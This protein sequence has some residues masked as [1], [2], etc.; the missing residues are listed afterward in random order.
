MRNIQVHLSS[1]DKT[2]LKRYITKGNHYSWLVLCASK[3]SWK[4]CKLLLLF[5]FSLFGYSQ[6]TAQS[7][8][9]IC[10]ERK[11]MNE[12]GTD[13][14]LIKTCF[15]NGFK[16]ISTSYPDYAGRYFLTDSEVFVKI[17]NKYV[18]T[19]NSN[20]FNH[21]QVTLLVLINKQ[22]QK[23][24]AAF[25]ADKNVNECLSGIDCIPEY[26][27]DDLKIS[28]YQNE[29]WFEAHW[30][31]GGVCRSVDGTIVSLQVN[32]ISRYLN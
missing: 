25:K 3:L 5:A 28:F 7:L 10:S 13:P 30:G 19:K 23:D 16:F 22:I 2:F 15:F 21:K 4:M 29:I 6:V 17:K 14:I 1:Q 8:K 24:F 9:L 31:L 26:K 11:K 20:V 18:A 32:K 27:M 12:D